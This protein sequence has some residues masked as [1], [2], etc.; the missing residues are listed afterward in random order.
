V[1]AVRT[2]RHAA[3]FSL[4]RLDEA[5]EDYRNIE[6]LCPTALDRADATAVQ[7]LS[8]SHRTRFAEAV[9]LGLQSL[10]ES[11][12][13]VPAADG[14]SAGL[15][16]QVDR[17][18]LWLDSTDPAED[19]ARPELSD[20]ELLATSRLIDALL[21]VANFVADRA[22]I[23]W[24]AAA[25]VRIWIEHGPSPLLIGPAAHAA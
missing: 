3:L 22:M 2:G 6:E 18:F 13:A 17:F 21:P 25:A 19:L 8:L 14:F 11:D 16:D 1:L 9:E 5:D 15:D 20:P 23:A 24:L 4:G 7:V 12:I 10:R